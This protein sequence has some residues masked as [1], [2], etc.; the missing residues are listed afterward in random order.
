M[1]WTILLAGVFLPVAAAMAVPVIPIGPGEFVSDDDGASVV[2]TLTRPF[3][4]A[5]RAVTVQEFM[6]YR[7]ATHAPDSSGLS[8]WHASAEIHGPHWPAGMVT[9]DD[10]LRY[11][12]WLSE[13]DGF[14][15]AYDLRGDQPLWDREADGWRLPTEAEWQFAALCGDGCR[16]DERDTSI[17]PVTV[18]PLNDL[19]LAGMLDD[20]LEWC[21]D[22]YQTWRRPVLV[23]PVGEDPAGRRVVRGI[24][25]HGRQWAASGFRSGNLGFRLARTPTP[26]ATLDSMLVQQR[27]AVADRRHEFVVEAVADSLLKRNRAQR[28]RVQGA[29]RAVAGIGCL[30]L[31]WGW[32]MIT[33]DESTEE[34]RKDGLD[35]IGIGLG[36]AALGGLIYLAAA[37]E[38]PRDKALSRARKVVATR[39]LAGQPALGLCLSF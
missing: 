2:I 29:G 5:T 16:A 33:D 25:P 28:N 23:D 30:S 35:V 38:M 14:S 6:A 17:Y 10:A 9:F 4:L 39:R 20:L 36:V 21:F 24:G 1:R 12:N 15:P 13:Q 19:G 27:L 3:L 26:S 32:R 7:R 8:W 37:R 31:V 18:A 34:S 22:G 11:A